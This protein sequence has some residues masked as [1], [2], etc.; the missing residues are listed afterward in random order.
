MAA[1]EDAPKRADES[2]EPKGGQTE[3]G[4]SEGGAASARPAGERRN[5]ERRQRPPVTIDL[6]AESVAAKAPPSEPKPEAEAD[7]PPRAEPE[8]SPKAEPDKPPRAEPD[9]SKVEAD[10]SPKAEP[11]RPKAERPPIDRLGDRTTDRLGAGA[12]ALRGAASRAF[13]SDDAWRRSAYAGIVGGVLAF[14]LV[15]VL[16]AVGLL[17]APG[18]ATANQALEQAKGAADTATAQ[19]R[20]ITAME[21]MTEG[22]TAMRGDIRSLSDRATALEGGRNALAA[23]SDVEAVSTALAGLRKQVDDAPPPATR[24]DL[25]AV[26]ERIGRLEV[27]TASGADGAGASEAA[28]S[29]L[30]SQISAAQATIRTLDDRLRAAETKL[31]A[32]GGPVSG[33]E[34]AVRAIAISSLRRAS[35]GDAPFAADLDLV[36]PLGVVPDQIAKLRPMAA[37]GVASKTTLSAAFPAV[38]DAILAA[39]TG[40]DP[41]A[42]LLQRAV[43]VLGSLVTIRPV[44]P[45]AG[46]DPPAIVSRMRDA[47]GRGD[48]AAALSERDGLPA[49]G[50]DASAAW[51]AQAADRVALDGLVDAVAQSAEGTSR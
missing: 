1:D 41:D 37:S 34:E 44:G 14:I 26:N 32:L 39:T 28:V 25:D 2:G 17:P 46:S 20:R 11:E 21:A 19:E 13:R 7:K 8:K 12:Q 33:G 50:K 16:Q 18:R 27:A 29:S 23:R 40:A 15:L 42:G 9:K 30:T 6:T 38:A 5:Q 45:V 24:A 51:A 3:G 47:V 31:A 4:P 22:L 36:A 35:E 48:L 49:A 10:K 43:G